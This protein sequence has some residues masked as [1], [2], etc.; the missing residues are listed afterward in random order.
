MNVLD[1]IENELLTC[2][3]EALITEGRPV[4]ECHHFAGDVPP[5]GDRCQANTA[6]Q[7]GQAWV[8]RASTAIEADADMTTFAGFTCD[9]TW[10]AQIEIGIYRCISA[11]PDESGNAPSPSAYNA[12]RELL[13]ADRATLAQVLCCW[14][15][16]GEPAVQQPFELG[17]TVV[18]AQILPLG[19]TGG[20]AGSVMMLVVNTALTAQEEEGPIFVSGPAAPA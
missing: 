20:C 7:N 2:L 11:V 6:G 15:L 3:C 19:P 4:C 8:R 13:A 18:G 5:V 1:Y 12:D 10:Q 16:S 14:P 17:I 9:G